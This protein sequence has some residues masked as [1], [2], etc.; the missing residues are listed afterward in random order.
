MPRTPITIRVV[1][2]RLA[3]W[4]HALLALMLMAM[5]VGFGNAWLAGLGLAWMLLV[6]WRLEQGHACGELRIVPEGKSGCRWNWWPEAGVERHDVALRCRYLGPWLIALE[7]D[8]RSLWLWP[9]SSSP[10]ALRQLRRWLVLS[11]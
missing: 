7:I 4:V 2:S 8:G 9:D 3:R 11:A 10:E 5:L 6:A 1:P